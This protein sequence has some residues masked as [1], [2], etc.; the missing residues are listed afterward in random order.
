MRRSLL[1]FLIAWAACSC[2]SGPA[3][4]GPAPDDEPLFPIVKNGLYG[5]MDRSG[6]IVIEPRFPPSVD[7]S[8]FEIPQAF[9]EGLAAVPERGRWGYIGTSGRWDIPPRFWQAADFHEGL[10]R[11][12]REEGENEEF[13]DRTGRVVIR[14]SGLCDDDFSEGRVQ[15]RRAGPPDRYGYLDRHGREIIP[16]RFDSADSF[17]EGLAAVRIEGQK[18]GYIDRAG[19]WAIP[20]SF[21]E[22]GSFSGGVA[23]VKAGEMT[24]NIDRQG[25]RVPGSPLE[26]PFASSY[27]IEPGET[28][29]ETGTFYKGVAV[30]NVHRFLETGEFMEKHGYVNAQGTVLLDPFN[31]DGIQAGVY[32]SC[33]EKIE[34]IVRG[35]HGNG[36]LAYEISYRNGE[37][38]G[39]TRYYDSGGRLKEEGNY[40]GF[41]KTGIWTRYTVGGILRC[42]YR[43]DD[44]WEGTL[45]R[46]QPDPVFPSPENHGFDKLF[47]CGMSLS[48]DDNDWQLRLMERGRAA[49][50]TYREGKVVRVASAD[51]N[52]KLVREFEF[53]YKEYGLPHGLCLAWNPR[54]GEVARCEYRD[55]NPYEGKIL[56]AVNGESDSPGIALLNGHFT[57]QTPAA[58]EYYQQG[59]LIRYVAADRLGRLLPDADVRY[60]DGEPTGVV[61]RFNRRG[62]TTAEAFIEKGVIREGT[63]LDAWPC[64]PHYVLMTYRDGKLDVMT[65]CDREGNRK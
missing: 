6:R 47:I 2:R 15:I 65:P 62:E 14:P 44:P 53:Q 36:N 8:Y 37:R 28:K 18:Y 61:R 31:P 16:F 9:H 60:S 63:I 54:G 30:L 5:Y 42:E 57:P 32:C 1:P 45:L 34:R 55:G 25:N 56:R 7:E 29:Y 52:G 21:D 48:K 26:E 64:P 59:R 3:E 22:A 4:R 17:Q 23:R 27:T 51:R 11:V 50:V 39:P 13:I 38:N 49:L 12:C 19:R 43:D 35:Y 33:L 24:L 20:P 41:H 40:H 58:V 10:A 46:F